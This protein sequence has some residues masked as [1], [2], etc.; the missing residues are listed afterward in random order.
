MHLK[1]VSSFI[2]IMLNL[3]PLS[4]H[5]KLLESSM[6]KLGYTTPNRGEFAFRIQYHIINEFNNLVY[7]KLFNYFNKKEKLLRTTF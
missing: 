2:V 4:I 1:V 7:R 3:A 6:N 5:N